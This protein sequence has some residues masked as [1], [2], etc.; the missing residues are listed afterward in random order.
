MKKITIATSLLMCTLI[1]AN[2]V[3]KTEVVP[4][5][6][7]TT[8]LTTKNGLILQGNQK[9]LIIKGHDNHQSFKLPIIKA[10]TNLHIYALAEQS[11]G[12]IIIGG[13]F[14]T[15]N[16]YK[17]KDI[18]RLNLDGSVD[19][20]FM[21]DYNGFNGEVYDL[22]VLDD[23]SILVGGYFT[24]LGDNKIS[25]GLVKL[26]DD[27][28]ID[29]RYDTLNKFIVSIVNDINIINN[30]IYLAGTFMQNKTKQNAILAIDK[31][32]N[33]DTTFNTKTNKIE[34]DGYK[35]IRKENSLILLGTMNVKNND[36]LSDVIKINANGEIDK[37]FFVSNLQG[38]VF[39]GKQQN[40]KLI[41]NGELA[42]K[43]NKGI[44]KEVHTAILNTKKE[45]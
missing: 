25:K 22:E 39:D 27:G 17:T 10:K 41:I 42:V 32:G 2:N 21:S 43:N 28:D 19:K 3:Q 26:T 34:G 36:K 9:G 31:S 38:F 18:V 13:N 24:E 44:V 5:T 8:S 37:N 35:I 11:D 14:D 16:G 20:G 6:Y 30:K 29:L 4:D 40:N 33:M 12:K 23:N 1:N 7:K 45:K 15:V